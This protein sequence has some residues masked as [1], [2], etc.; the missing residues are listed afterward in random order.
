MAGNGRK[1]AY[2]GICAGGQ[3]VVKPVVKPVVKAV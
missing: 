3:A 1:T 2:V